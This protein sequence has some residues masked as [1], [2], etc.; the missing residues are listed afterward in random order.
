[1]KPLRLAI[2]FDQRL[3]SGG[4]YQQALSAAMLVKK[5]PRRLVEPIFF[6][7]LKDNIDVLSDYDI[8]PI[9]INLSLSKVLLLYLRRFLKSSRFLRLIKYF[10]KYNPYE[11]IFV[12]NY[13]SIWCI[14]FLQVVELWILRSSIIFQRFGIY[15]IETT[16]NF[17]GPMES[18]IRI[19]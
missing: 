16:R 4:G 9:V 14:I 1:M 7:T 12:S 10:Q 5:L 17:R 8:S 18:R 15:A 11:S 2:I 6:T 19:T 3:Y 13:I